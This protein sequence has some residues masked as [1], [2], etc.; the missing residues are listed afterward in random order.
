LDAGSINEVTPDPEFGGNTGVGTGNTVSA[1]ES[2]ARISVGTAFNR[3]R[4]AASIG[5]VSSNV[6]DASS[7]SFGLS[8][9]LQY[10]VA[11]MTLGAA[12]RDIGSGNLPTEARL[13]LS[14]TFVNSKNVGA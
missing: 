10:D 13:G 9:G 12:I 1:S 4:A 8:A 7:Q 3:I 5:F 2:A 14:R 11:N 6:A